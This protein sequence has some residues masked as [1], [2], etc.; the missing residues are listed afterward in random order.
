MSRIRILLALYRRIERSIVFHRFM[1]IAFQHFLACHHS[2]NQL[3]DE[4]FDLL[5]SLDR[6]NLF[7]NH[8]SIKRIN[9]FL[10]NYI[11][12]LNLCTKRYFP[13][14]QFLFFNFV[15][16]SELSLCFAGGPLAL[17]HRRDLPLILGLQ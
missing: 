2:I 15:V 5:F 8:R 7:F 12:S 17:Y 9:R 3:S 1:K 11:A 13:T 14:F 10:H 4:T 6:R 16:L